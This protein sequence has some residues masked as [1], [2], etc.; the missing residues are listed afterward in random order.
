MISQ[1]LSSS[2]R[3]WTCVYLAWKQSLY[4]L[5]Y[6][7][8]TP[9]CDLTWSKLVACVR[10]FLFLASFGFFLWES[11]WE[12][13]SHLSS[14]LFSVSPSEY[15]YFS[16]TQGNRKW[17]T[18]KQNLGARSRTPQFIQNI[19]FP[20]N[21]WELLVFNAMHSVGIWLIPCFF[22]GILH[23]EVWL[24]LFIG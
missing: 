10:P 18:S 19:L 3:I 17:F 24:R 5:C 15:F 8:E 7:E 16:E 22:K 14:P 6:P 1:R 20:C 23:F 12:A 4:T 9:A 2:I 21:R 11:I 13:A